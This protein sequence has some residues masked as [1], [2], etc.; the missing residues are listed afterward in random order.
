MP[1]K[2]EERR[3]RALITKGTG[4]GRRE[5]DSTPVA[6]VHE[7]N[8]QPGRK[9]L[10]ASA[11][12]PWR[13]LAEVLEEAA[14]HDLLREVLEAGRDVNA[15]LGD[16]LAVV[17]PSGEALLILSTERGI[18]VRRHATDDDVALFLRRGEVAA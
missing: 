6:E 14:G 8:G 16:G 17:L 1:H 10:G 3:A 9:S 13:R 4:Q 5:E 18:E 2:S 12:P 11:P 7:A 15:E